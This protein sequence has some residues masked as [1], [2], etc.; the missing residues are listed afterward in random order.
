MNPAGFPDEVWLRIFAYIIDARSLQSLVLSC[1]LFHNLGMEEL[2]RTLVWNT[3]E[4]TEA[5]L[6]F[7]EK[8]T[9]RQHIPKALS[10]NMNL[11]YD[12]AESHPAI[13]RSATRFHS[14]SSLSLS[15]ARLG[16]TFYQV[17]IGL[18]NLTH[19][20]VNSCCLAAAPPHFPYSFPSF[21]ANGTTGISVTDLTIQRISTYHHVYYSDEE[22]DDD[23]FW[24]SLPQRPDLAFFALLPHLRALTVSRYVKIPIANL[25]QLT[26]LTLVAGMGT[27]AAIHLLN[28]YLP[29]TPSLLHLD[30]GL[31][32]DKWW[33][34]SREPPELPALQGSL[35]LLQS[36]TGPAI[37][38]ASIIPDSPALASL[39]INNFLVKMEEALMLVERVNADSLHEIDLRLAKWDDEVLLAIT[40][41]LTECRDVRIVYCF[42]EPSNV[43]M[44]NL[45]IHHLEHLDDLH[46][47][48][49]HAVPP[50]PL[51][52][53][54]GMYVAPHLRPVETRVPAVVPA[55][56]DCAENLAVW[57]RY[58]KALREVRF[59]EGR[60]WIRHYARGK[61]E[62]TVVESET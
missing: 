55:E 47:L 57:S 4:K 36:F 31:T 14:L 43:F 15:N 45:G 44:F 21:S 32:T 56:E 38:A 58:T 16:P 59:V 12:A 22:D 41:R 30:V 13:L 26:S 7:W 49:V 28:E 54:N 29:H 2:L 17:L 9:D 6:E 50:P 42:S 1:S 11:K 3:Q 19:L 23:G 60:A 18:P 48:H 62:V 52:L 37:I 20:S 51:D 40:Q 61:W 25:P 33:D 8:S 27:G 5:N 35:P 24:V 46:T 53:P 39:K 10:I 34:P